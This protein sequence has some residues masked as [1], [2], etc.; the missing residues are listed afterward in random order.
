VRNARVPSRA[1]SFLPASSGVLRGRERDGFVVLPSAPGLLRGEAV[2]VTRGPFQDRLGL[3]EGQAPH[4]RVAILLTWLGSSRR[5]ELPKGDIA[6][7]G[8]R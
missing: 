2:R 3:Y 5:I 1:I 6:P 7:V 8:A 4:E